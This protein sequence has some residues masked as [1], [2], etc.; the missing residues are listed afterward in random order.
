MRRRDS[1]DPLL[2]PFYFTMSGHCLTTPATGPDAKSA[3][4]AGHPQARRNMIYA[5]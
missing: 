3:V 1:A 5:V 2:S 4:H